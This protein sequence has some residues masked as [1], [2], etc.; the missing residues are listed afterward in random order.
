[1]EETLNKSGEKST[2]KRSVSK[3]PFSKRQSLSA[4]PPAA[5][6]PRVL[7]VLKK[8]EIEHYKA[9]FAEAEIKFEDFFL[10]QKE[11]LLEM[12]LP[13]GVRNRIIECQQF[14]K[15]GGEVKTVKEILHKKGFDLNK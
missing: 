12:R 6:S 1:M 4:T 11:D 7:S 14:Y 13:I 15:T 10:L 9:T 2:I 5:V 8:L 3:S